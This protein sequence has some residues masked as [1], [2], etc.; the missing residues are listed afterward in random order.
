[1][2]TDGWEQ[3]S[4]LLSVG[5]IFIETELDKQR[6]GV[7]EKAGKDSLHMSLNNNTGPQEQLCK[8]ESR[9]GLGLGGEAW[10]GDGENFKKDNFFNHCPPNSSSP[11]ANDWITDWSLLVPML[12][13]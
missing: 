8:G 7:R 4:M 2:E 6:S 12:W 11:T 5:G 13:R 3:G 1:M 10:M 9:A